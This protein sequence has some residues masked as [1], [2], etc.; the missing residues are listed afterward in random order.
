MLLA[1]AVGV[2][3]LHLPP[4]LPLHLHLHQEARKRKADII[5]IRLTSES[6]IV[7]YPFNLVHKGAG[8]WRR[9]FQSLKEK[10][11]VSLRSIQTN[12]GCAG[13]G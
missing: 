5:R 12:I 11:N 8:H 10:S 7:V 13:W 1:V 3:L 2:L 9:P 4:L 6:E